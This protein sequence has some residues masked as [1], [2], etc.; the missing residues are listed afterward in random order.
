MFHKEDDNWIKR[1][2]FISTASVP[3]IKVV[4]EDNNYSIKV[5]ITFGDETHKGSHCVRLVKDY[6]RQFGIL[7]RMV[8]V[9]KQLLKVKDLNDPYKGGISSYALTLMIV[10][11]LQFQFMY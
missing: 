5:D 9:I 1:I 11:F 3:I 2:D 7:N 6:M 10:A 8:M 4:T